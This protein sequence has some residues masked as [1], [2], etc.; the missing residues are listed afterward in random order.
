MGYWNDTAFVRRISRKTVLNGLTHLFGLDGYVY[1]GES[2]ELAAELMKHQ[3][4][5]CP[6]E[7]PIWGAA[8]IPGDKGWSILKLVPSALL[9]GE[10]RGGCRPRLGTL[11]ALMGCVG[12]DIHVY[13][14]E[15]A[16]TLEAT[17]YGVT[18]VSGQTYEDLDFWFGHRAYEGDLP[19]DDLRM[20]GMQDREDRPF[21]IY[22]EYNDLIPPARPFQSYEETIRAI[23]AG[24]TGLGEEAY[25]N[26]IQAECI[27]RGKPLPL[28]S[29]RVWYFR[30]QS[31][32]IATT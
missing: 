10:A 28:S 1:A 17:P 11:C 9:T 15:C 12:L 13:D 8:W 25:D 14:S 16:L 26:Q 7:L 6:T 4:Y 23:G 20:G 24:L 22:P 27:A 19:Q 32:S 21:V 30:K 18:L 5:T 3:Q 2:A 29:G 31:P